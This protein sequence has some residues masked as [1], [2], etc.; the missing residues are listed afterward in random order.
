MAANRAGVVIGRDKISVLQPKLGQEL[1]SSDQVTSP[2]KEKRINRSKLHTIPASSQK[3]AVVGGGHGHGN[4]YFD[5]IFADNLSLNGEATMDSLN[6]DSDASINSLTVTNDTTTGTLKANTMLVMPVINGMPVS[7]SPAGQIIYDKVDNLLYI[8]DGTFWHLYDNGNDAPLTITVN[9]TLAPNKSTIFTKFQDAIDSLRNKKITNTT[10]NVAA[11]KYIENLTFRSL[12]ASNL[13]TFIVN[14]DTRLVAGAGIAHGMYFNNTITPT[15]PLG[16]GSTSEA[17]LVGVIGGNTI[18]VTVVSI[19]TSSINPDFTA[20]GGVTNTDR[21]AVRHTD[22]TFAIY[23]ITAVA[24]TVLTISP[25]LSGN[26]NG[27]GAAIC[28]VPLAEI[29]PTAGAPITWETRAIL[30]GFFINIPATVDAGIVIR[31]ASRCNH[32]G[33]LFWGGAVSTRSNESY[34]VMSAVSSRGSTFFGATTEVY[35]GGSSL[36]AFANSLIAPALGG[37]GLNAAENVFILTPA[38]RF[39]G[40]AALL[41]ANNSGIS[42]DA[43]SRPIEF[44]YTG[45]GAPITLSNSATLLVNSGT[46]MRIR[47]TPSTGIAMSAGTLTMETTSTLSFSSTDPNA[48]ILDMSAS[49]SNPN[50]AGTSPAVGSKA[51]LNLDS[52]TLPSSP[53]AYIAK[54]TGGS[55]LTVHTVGTPTM[56][57]NSNGFLVDEDSNLVWK[58]T[59]TSGNVTGGGGTGI[60]FDVRRKSKVVIPPALVRTFATFGLF[61]NVDSDSDIVVENVTTIGATTHYK[62]DSLATAYVKNSTTT[63]ATASATLTNGSR[64]RSIG[65]T[66][67]PAPT[68]DATSLII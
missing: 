29:A 2:Q 3:D 4:G 22:G 52:F 18:S 40:N 31:G 39:I 67:S 62:L 5:D 6:V 21:V 10:F 16:G 59:G 8:S 53:T 37:R 14:G 63:G 47:G 23:N 24:P 44:Y 66:F 61:F 49:I 34:T 42:F 58:A 46:A 35:R 7:P 45:T 57:T 56:G 33:C 20:P 1:A 30:N 36:A 64:L 43:T 17:F 26:V 15:V 25:P 65:N 50:P 60:L 51:N 38:T 9:S 27:L 11:G 13:G 54:V 48:T 19:T 12:L 41:Q 32:S 55:S 28:I 68:A